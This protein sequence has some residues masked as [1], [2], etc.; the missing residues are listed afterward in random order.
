MIVLNGTDK[1]WTYLL[2]KISHHDHVDLDILASM[3]TY[4]RISMKTIEKNG[5]FKYRWKHLDR[6]KRDTGNIT[7]SPANN[8]FTIG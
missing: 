3:Q 6:S 7:S 1:D 4:K 2:S 8:R 5:L